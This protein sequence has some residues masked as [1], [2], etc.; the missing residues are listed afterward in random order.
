VRPSNAETSRNRFHNV[1]AR[2]ESGAASVQLST[3]L[4]TQVEWPDSL[5]LT[6]G[7]ETTPITTG[8]A[9]LTTRMPFRMY[10][11]EVRASL[12]TAQTGGSTFTV[13][14]EEGGTSILS[15]P[16]TIDNGEKR[17]ADAAVPAVIS[18]PNLE[19]D[20]EITIDVPTAGNGTAAGLKVTLVGIRL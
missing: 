5:V 14:I 8:N 11:T 12:S 15:T 16:L 2:N 13:D 10:V 1:T 18:D 9:K 3:S 4:A 17:S 7:D 19:K 6:V 20:A